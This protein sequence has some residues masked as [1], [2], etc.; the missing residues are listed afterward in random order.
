MSLSADSTGLE[1]VI[2][3]CRYFGHD[4]VMRLKTVNPTGPGTIV[5]RVSGSRSAESGDPS[6]GGLPG[7]GCGLSPVKTAGGP[8]CLGRES[9]HARKAQNFSQFLSGLLEVF[10]KLST[11]EQ[12]FGDEGGTQLPRLDVRGIV[13][14]RR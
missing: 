9:L 6:L 8:V 7:G 1:A 5:V 14:P 4:A 10:A 12:S 13:H 2:E 3:S 11:R